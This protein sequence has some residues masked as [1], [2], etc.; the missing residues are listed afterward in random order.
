MFDII[1]SISARTRILRADTKENLS[2]MGKY[3]KK[4]QPHK[5]HRKKS[6]SKRT[7]L[8][9]SVIVAVVLVAGVFGFFALTRDD[10]RIVGNLYVAGVDVGG[11]T[12]EEAKAALEERMKIYD[13]NAMQVELY[14]RSFPLYVTTYDP[15]KAL[16]DIFGKPME[17]GQAT[18]STENT[19]EPTESSETEPTEPTEPT[20]AAPEDAPLDEDGKP[21]EYLGTITISA[22][23]SG[24]SLN[25]D[26]AVEAA[27]NYG[28]TKLLGFTRLKNKTLAERK[29]LEAA[30]YLVLNE[31][32]IQSVLQTASDKY[33]SKLTESKAEATA[34]AEKA[35][36]ITFGTKESKIDVRTLYEQLRQAYIAANFKQQYVMQ[37]TF[38]AAV[39]L[40]AL[41]SSYCTAP[42]NAVCDE[43][44]YEITEGAEGYGFDMAATMELLDRAKPGQSVTIEMGVLEPMYTRE[45]LEKQLF[46]DVLASVKSPHDGPTPRTTNLRLACEQIDGYILKPGETFSYNKVVGERTE[47]R[48]F[49]S[50]GAYVGDETVEVTGGGVC[51]VASTLYYCTLQAELEVV[52]RTEHRYYPWYIPWGLDAT[53]YWGS[54]DYRF[55]NNTNYPIRIDASIIGSYVVVEFVGTETRNYTVK[56]DYTVISSN[57]WEL[58][59]VEM[60][61]EEAAEKGYTDGEVLVT[62]YSGQKVK[63]YKYKYDKDGNELSCEFI[64]DSNYARR[65]KQVVKIIYP[66]EP[67]TEPSE[68]TEPSTETPTEPE[69]PT[70]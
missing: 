69:T 50:A 17:P 68:P 58:V 48:G 4:P 33:G 16:V 12:R 67:S 34:G 7:A 9:V 30:D 59:E 24:V 21:M 36:H 41:Y 5:P 56:L 25:T 61:P 8:L 46:S 2:S 26:A 6:G 52:E 31:T 60:T 43:E 40:D 10:G 19:D 39:D 37:E 27:Y 45:K 11:M 13:E 23:E 66:P 35:L 55:R 3:E 42:V 65:D 28:R 20:E 44:T 38:P 18:Q 54:L 49:L 29:D 62:P 57:Q 47:A 15:E 1:R 53:V 63:S 51:Q 32:K 22:A 14:G 64:D 70:P